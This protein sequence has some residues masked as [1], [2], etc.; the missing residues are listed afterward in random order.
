M[1]DEAEAGGL[2]ALML[3]QDSRRLARI[4]ATACW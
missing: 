1:P 4:D 2:L 3:L